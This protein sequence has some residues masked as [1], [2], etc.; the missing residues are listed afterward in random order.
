MSNPLLDITSLPAFDRITSDHAEP[1]IDHCL[2]HCRAVLNSVTETDDPATWASVIEP[3][4]DADDRLNRAWSPISHLNSVMNHDALRH[5]YNECR[6][7]LSDYASEVGQHDALYQR[8]QEISQHSDLNSAQQQVL[9][10]ALRDFFLS[11]VTLPAEQKARY[12]AINQSLTKLTSQY[13]ENV[14]DATQAWTLLID[15]RQRLAGVPESALALARQQAQNRELDGWLLTLEMPSYLP[16][17]M[18]AQDRALREQMYTAYCTRAS[19]VGPHAGQW[20]NSAV[21][22]QILALRHEQAQLLGFNHYAELSLAT[23]MA[24]DAEAVVAFLNELATHT[25][26]YAR[27]EFAQL[28]DFAARQDGLTSLQAWDVAYYSE[29]LRQQ[30]YALDQELLRPYFPIHHVLT[31]LFTIAQRLFGMTIQAV[32]DA[33]TWHPDVTLYAIHDQ[34][35]TVCAWFYLDPYARQNKRGGAWMDGCINRLKNSQREQVP[36]A[37]L[38][39][40]F[41]PPL[42]DCPSLL[43]HRDVETLFHEFGHGVHHMLTRIDYSAV[44]G[45]NGVPWD[46]VELPSQLLE[47]WCWEYEALQL[48]ARHYQTDEVLPYSLF[49]RLQATRHFQAGM[50]MARQLEFALFDF[51][52]HRDYD[53]LQGAQIEQILQQ[54]RTQ[55]A[56]LQPPSFN[57]FAHAF[58]HIFAGGYAAGYYSYKWAEVL[59]ADAFALFKERGIFDAHTGQ[60]FRHHILEQGGAADTMAL[61]KAF[62]GR[63]P[64]VTALLNQYGMQTA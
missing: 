40:N 57:R 55:V 31:G 37:Y 11:G 64:D 27:R 10:H 23:K 25:M 29:Q 5:T 36:V 60:A 32:P 9:R 63:E 42:P 59:S 13:E 2:Q 26:P 53:P 62:R 48:F 44:S 56:V 14:L 24:P 49:E 7:K 33:V 20:D 1:A 22:E 15:D 46:A 16:I 18:Y 43:T 21:M 3:L 58:S 50:A 4:E 38:V 28:Q 39:C 35:G 12:K 61:F 17:L 41:P 30:H 19:D 52:V 54:V 8:Y 51:H 6:V 34:Q 45:I 47:N